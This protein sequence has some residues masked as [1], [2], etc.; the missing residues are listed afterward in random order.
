MPAVLFK[1]VEDFCTSF[2]RSKQPAEMSQDDPDQIERFS[3]K[4]QLREAV[5]PSVL[6]MAIPFMLD[7]PN[8]TN[9]FVSKS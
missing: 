7:N 1:S 5:H 8:S 2:I 4:A 6:L 9:R 3:N